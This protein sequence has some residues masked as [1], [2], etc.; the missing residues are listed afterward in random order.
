MR[1]GGC[2]AWA[3]PACLALAGQAAPPVV[4]PGA[5]GPP[6]REYQPPPAPVLTDEQLFEAVNQADV[7]F[8]GKVARMVLGPA[9][10]SLPPHYSIT[11][12]FQAVLAIRGTVAADATFQYTTFRPRDIE[13]GKSVLVAAVVQAPA[14][15]APGAL[16]VT[17]LELPT[18]ARVDVAALAARTPVGWRFEAGRPVSPFAALGDRAWP[19]DAPAGAKLRCARTGRPALPAGPD[20]TLKVER[21]PAE[22]PIPHVNP[23]GD[24]KFRI[25]VTN[26]AKT[27]VRC[28]ALLTVRRDGEPKILWAD[29]LVLLCRGKPYVLPGAG[30]VTKDVQPA[31]LAAGQS[32]STVVDVLAV[33]GIPWVAGGARMVFRFAI[34][35]KSAEDFFYYLSR[36]HGKLH[37]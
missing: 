16:R 10:R 29:S 33:P 25:T 21:I 22:E 30:A 15:G 31:R 18:P 3:L 24:G 13:P 1:N 6:G 32:V 35:E 27:E 36:H 23:Y 5:E 34:G 11:L 28:P 14:G 9:T 19:K 17:H 7:A 4:G 8:T 20:V 12:Q 37:K 26:T 2:R